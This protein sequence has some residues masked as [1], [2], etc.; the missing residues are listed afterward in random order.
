MSH[1]TGPSLAIASGGAGRRVAAAPSG[2]GVL[3]LSYQRKFY[4]VDLRGIMIAGEH[5]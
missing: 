2:S 4:A 5:R 3:F 1:A